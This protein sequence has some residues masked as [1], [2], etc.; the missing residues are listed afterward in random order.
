MADEHDHYTGD[1]VLKLLE[2]QSDSRGGGW[3]HKTE[4]VLRDD[5]GQ[6]FVLSLETTTSTSRS[7]IEEAT[8]SGKA[9]VIFGKVVGQSK[10]IRGTIRKILAV[11]RAKT[12]FEYLL[13]NG[14]TD[15]SYLAAS[16]VPASIPNPFNFG[17]MH[18]PTV[19]PLRQQDYL[20]EI[21][22]YGNGED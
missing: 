9:A 11:N 14:G 15:A 20:E 2:V 16:Y 17:G 10:D 22:A 19:T 13:D 3:F 7:F 1:V 18:Q 5:S 12:K 21:G 4:V 6:E 8:Q